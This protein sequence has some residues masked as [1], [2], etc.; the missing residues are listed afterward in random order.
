M[1]KNIQRIKKL[2]EKYRELSKIDCPYQPKA[3][4][5]SVPMEEYYN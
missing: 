2:R 3:I 1:P 5:D 4:E